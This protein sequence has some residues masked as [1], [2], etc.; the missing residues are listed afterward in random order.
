MRWVGDARSDSGTTERPFEVDVEGRLVPGI[1]WLPSSGRPGPRP[2]V[3]AGHGATHHKRVEYIRALA[4]LLVRRHDF[5]VAAIDGPG[6]GDRRIDPRLDEIQVFSNFLSEWSRPTSTDDH[7]AEWQA[8]LT[9][10]REQDEVGDGP[11][12]Y[13]GLSMGTIY[14]LPF[15]ASEPRVQAAVLGLM[16][17]I[18]PT[19]D[20]LELDAKTI[21]CPVLFLQ[22]WDDQLVSRQSVLDLFDALGTLD[23]RLH[24]HPGEHAAV[25]PEELRFSAEFLV[26]HLAPGRLE[27]F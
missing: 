8:A 3:L 25:P 12:G 2:L 16:G 4:H 27:D 26:R 9:A 19:R 7:V 6:H 13:W 5:A 22:Q 24:A 14:G 1:L 15:V 11:L 21:T 18:G 23:K 20:R 17:L 10:L